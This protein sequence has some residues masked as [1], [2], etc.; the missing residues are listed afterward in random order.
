MATKIDA[1]H[2]IT[3]KVPTQALQ[4]A[5]LDGRGVGLNGEMG[6]ISKDLQPKSILWYFS[7]VVSKLCVFTYV[8]ICVYLTFTYLL[9]LSSRPYWPQYSLIPL[10]P[11]WRFFNES[12]GAFEI[13]LTHKFLS[14]CTASQSPDSVSSLLL[15]DCLL[16]R[17]LRVLRRSTLLSFKLANLQQ[18]G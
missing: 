4:H 13:Y 6:K 14:A 8:C 15:S 17:L 16:L 1:R 5:L 11:G 9:S 12:F 3:D 2:G 7:S 18:A 10:V